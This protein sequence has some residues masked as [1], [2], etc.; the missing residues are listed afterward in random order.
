MKN[1]NIHVNF[2]I[3]ALG[4]QSSVSGIYDTERDIEAQRPLHVM[5]F[6]C[7]LKSGRM[8]GFQ[9]PENPCSSQ[10]DILALVGCE[11]VIYLWGEGRE[12]K[13]KP[14]VSKSKANTR[15]EP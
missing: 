10:P 12:R 6:E 9:P 14:T 5:Y 8:V 2:H 3:E 4:P 7:S 13:A 15:A 11:G 1:S